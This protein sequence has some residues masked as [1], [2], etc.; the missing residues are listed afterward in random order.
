[1]ALTRQR[2]ELVV[3]APGIMHPQRRLEDVVGHECQADRHWA[4]QPRQRQA[5]EQT[6]DDALVSAD[7]QKGIASVRIREGTSGANLLRRVHLHPAPYDVQW[8]RGHLRCSSA[9]ASSSKSLHQRHLCVACNAVLL[10]ELAFQG[11]EGGERDRAVR[12]HPEQSRR[13]PL[14]KT[15]E[16]FAQDDFLNSRGVIPVVET[17]RLSRS[18]HVQWVCEDSGNHAR[19]SASD[20]GRRRFRVRRSAKRRLQVSVGGIEHEELDTRERHDAPERR[21]VALPKALHPR[22]LDDLSGDEARPAQSERLRGVNL[23]HNP[24]PIEGRR[25]RFRDDASH[26]S[27]DENIQ[28]AQP[29]LAAR[30][31]RRRHVAIYSASVFRGGS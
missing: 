11:I 3:V 31:H 2:D 28:R 19:R 18:E 8:V 15:S 4:L 25:R 14:P 5:F 26:R 10:P 24:H 13:E 6:V 22:F 21:Q 30:C 16:P 7:L 17:D 27:N 1:M 20:E 9:E 12:E 29:N 23:E